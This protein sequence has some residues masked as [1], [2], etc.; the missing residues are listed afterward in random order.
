MGRVVH[1][2]ITADD[3]ERA[4]G[5][6]QKA[7]GWKIERY[8]GGEMPYWLVETGTDGVPGING[9][10][11]GRMAPGQSTI[12]TATVDKL[13]AAM[14]SV[15]QAGGTIVGEIQTIPDVGRFVYAID[16]E[17]NSFGLMEEAPHTH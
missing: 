16:T 4:V 2:E 14:D 17:G 8:E 1:F 11:M 15:R 5:F 3:P 7:L 10:I 13:E 9:G 6:Y 12:N